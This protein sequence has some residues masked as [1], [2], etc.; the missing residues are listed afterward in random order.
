MIEALITGERGP[1]MLADLARER[2]R[3]KIP[4]LTLACAGRFS[5]QHALMCTLHLEHID[6]LA[7]MIARWTLGSTR[8]PSLRPA[9]DLA[10]DDPGNR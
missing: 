9:N 7:G 3:T 5:D 10:G 1:A 6:H 8:P 4:E 2:M